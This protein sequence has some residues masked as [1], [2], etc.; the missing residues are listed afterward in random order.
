MDEHMNSGTLYAVAARKSCQKS[1]IWTRDKMMISL[2]PSVNQDNKHP[3]QSL[4]ML[5]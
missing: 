5:V 2:T 4:S 1:S 3:T